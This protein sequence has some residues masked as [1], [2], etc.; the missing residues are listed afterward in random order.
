MNI[1]AVSAYRMPVHYDLSETAIEDATEVLA[2]EHYDAPLMLVVASDQ[3]FLAGRLCQKYGLQCIV[4]PEVMKL[5]SWA[6]AGTRS[7]IWSPGT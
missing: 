5:E 1:E 3:Q 6:L 4:I 2:K 7:V